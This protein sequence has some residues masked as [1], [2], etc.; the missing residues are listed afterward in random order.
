MFILDI[1]NNLY[2]KFLDF[3]QM[4]SGNSKKSTEH[5]EH[6][7]TPIDPEQIKMIMKKY[8][9]MIPIIVKKSP[10]DQILADFT[11]KFL[12]G[13]DVLMSGIVTL[14]RRKFTPLRNHQES[15]LLQING[16]DI[17]LDKTVYETYQNYKNPETGALYVTYYSEFRDRG[18]NRSINNYQN[19]YQNNQPYI[20]LRSIASSS[21]QNNITINQP[22]QVS[23]Y[24]NR[25]TYPDEIVEKNPGLVCSICFEIFCDPVFVQES[26]QTYC[27]ECIDKC[28][29]DPKTRVNINKSNIKPNY[30]IISIIDY[31]DKN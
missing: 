12:S 27:R 29:T 25:K 5:T 16:Q 6:T 1:L 3:L 20:D 13:K 22:K 17:P 24:K 23:K 14:I 30:Q 26:G 8:P 31:L 2:V 10:N 7:E 9:N 19:N 18:S 11:G 28:T 15:I 4:G 21:N